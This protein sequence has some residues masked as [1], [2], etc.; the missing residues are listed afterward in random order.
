MKNFLDNNRMSALMTILV[1]AVGS[2]SI[3]GTSQF[4]LGQ[5]GSGSDGSVVGCVYSG[6]KN[7]TISGGSSGGGGGGA[8][9]TSNTATLNVIKKFTDCVGCK[10]IFYKIRVTGNNPQPFVFEPSETGTQVT[11][12]PGQYEVTEI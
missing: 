7:T 8:Q 6:C 2:I 1:L 11:I 10:V 4:V 5:D 12:G 3:V 9:P